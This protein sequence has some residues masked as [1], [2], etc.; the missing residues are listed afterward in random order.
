[1]TTYA[2]VCMADLQPYSNIEMLIE[3]VNRCVSGGCLHTKLT[4]PPA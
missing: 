1:M 4:R 2:D 3:T